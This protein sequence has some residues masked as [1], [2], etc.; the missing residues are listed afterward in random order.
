MAIQAE[1]DSI[2]TH[3][4]RISH[5]VSNPTLVSQVFVLRHIMAIMEVTH[6]A[7]AHQNT[8]HYCAISIPNIYLIICMPHCRASSKKDIF[9]SA[10]YHEIVKCTFLEDKC[11]ARVLYIGYHRE[12]HEAYRIT[13]LTSVKG[14]AI[15]HKDFL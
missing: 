9:P 8:G 15:N 12:S 6:D 14:N 5:Y 13:V 2:A 4:V 3:I 1:H 11:T 10:V 7:A